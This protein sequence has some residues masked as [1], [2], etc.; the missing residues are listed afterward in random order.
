MLPGRGRCHFGKADLLADAARGDVPDAIPD[1]AAVAPEP[2]PGDGHLKD[3]NVLDA[4][5]VALDD[6]KRCPGGL[7]RGVRPVDL[8]LALALAAEQAAPQDAGQVADR[9]CVA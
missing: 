8:A 1:A 6:V 9:G 4:P 5:P 2:A 7:V 3:H